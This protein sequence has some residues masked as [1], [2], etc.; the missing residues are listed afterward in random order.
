MTDSNRNLYHFIL[1]R[2]SGTA[3]TLDLDAFR[4]YIENT[5]DKHNIR[6]CVRLCMAADMGH[7]ID[8]AIPDNPAAII[9]GGGD[10]SVN[11]SAA[12]LCN[13]GIA[14]GILPLGTFNLC[15]RDHG[16]STDPKVAVVQ[17]CTASIQTVPLMRINNYPCLCTATI[18]FYP[19]L[20]KIMGKFKHSPWWARSMKIAVNTLF[21]FARCPAYRFNLSTYETNEYRKSRLIIIVPGFYK[22]TAG[23]I[24][25]RS[26]Q[27]HSTVSLYVFKHM[28]RLAVLRSIASYML[29]RFS[30]DPDIQAVNSNSVTLK[31]K[32]K[33]QIKVM[34]DGEIVQ[35]AN[36]LKI[37]ITPDTLKLLFPETIE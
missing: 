36:P 17:L 23:I 16:V 32:Y 15:A 18:G 10:G 30:N 14:L 1:N 13:T 22:D 26:A 2:E 35:L 12:L 37:D 3:R 29:G 34:I 5:L 9:V 24:P 28:G 8:S 4:K 7:A 19:R 20:M 11:T 33:K 6:A 27:A 31:F 21:Y 25:Q